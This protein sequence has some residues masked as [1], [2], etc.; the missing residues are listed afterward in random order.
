MSPDVALTKPTKDDVERLAGW[1]EDTEVNSSWYGRGEDGRPLHAGYTPS[2]LLEGGDEELD[3]VFNDENRRVFS[4][5]T[6]EGEHIGEGQL[7]VEWPLLEAQAYVLVGRK[8]LWHHHYGTNAMVGLLD[9]AFNDM[10]LHRVWVDVPDYNG[11]A[12]GM[13]KQLGFVL[14]G[15]FRKSHRRDDEWFDSSVLGLLADE[16]SRRRPRV[17]QAES[18]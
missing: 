13:V 10:G 5:Y 7:V 3:R 14:E 4:I 1:L 16:Y 9:Y 6:A 17:V 15:H 2:A 8:D 18:G 12:M 11:H